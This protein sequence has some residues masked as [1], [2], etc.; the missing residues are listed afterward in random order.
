MEKEVIIVGAG[1][2]GSLWAIYLTNAGYKVSIYESRSDIRK[3]EIKAGKSI[4]LALSDRGWNALQQ[5]KIDELIKPIAIPMSGRVMH[6]TT[7][8]L[9]YQAYGKENQA[10]YSISRGDLNKK[11]VEIA[12]EKGAQLFYNE[13]CIDTDTNK[14]IV[15]FQNSITKEIKTVKADLIFGADGAF[16]KVRYAGM[17]KLPRFNYSQ[18]Y[19]EDGYKE[20]LLPANENGN[21]KLDKNALHIWPRGRFMLIALPNDDGS[22]TCTLFMPYEGGENAF[23]SLDSDEKVTNFFKNPFPD[24]YD[25]MPNLLENWHAHPLSSLAIIRCFP[26]TNKTTALI[27]DAAHATVPFYGQ[28]MNASFEDC[29]VLN[30]LMLKH[31]H[32]WPTI[33]NEYEMVRK[34]DGDAIQDLS[35]HNYYVMRDYVSDPKFLLQKK[36]E[37][38]IFEKHPDKWM[39]LYSQV[40]FSQIRYSQAWN[41]GMKQEAIM[42]E[43]IALPNIEEKWDHKE[44]EELILTKL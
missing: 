28:G 9:T 20:L 25:M 37:A 26:W 18:K 7:G 11:M 19:I 32:D 3:A 15:T 40:T 33:F 2:A 42:K 44:I 13:K 14:G 34:P 35:L 1:L 5:A 38:R 16:S 23:D 21:Y 8:D 29:F 43:I 36:I 39:P 31:N 12:T 22:F 24:F 30:E 10:I 4:N 6:S 27:G 17:Q 41:V